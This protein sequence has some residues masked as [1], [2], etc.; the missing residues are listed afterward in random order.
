MEAFTKLPIYAE[1]NAAVKAFDTALEKAEPEIYKPINE[2]FN[3]KKYEEDVKSFSE[4]NDMY[5]E[6]KNV[7]DTKEANMK[8]VRMTLTDMAL[9]FQNLKKCLENEFEDSL[10]ITECLNYVVERMVDQ[11]DGTLPE[12]CFIEKRNELRAK[13]MPLPETYALTHSFKLSSK[14]VIDVNGLNIDLKPLQEWSGLKG[15][16]VLY[17]SQKDG[18]K[19]VTFNTALLHQKNAA[20]IFADEEENVFGYYTKNGINTVGKYCEDKEHFMF[21]LVKNHINCPKQFFAKEDVK[22][23]IFLREEDEVM[24]WIGNSD[25]GLAIFKPSLCGSYSRKLSLVYNNLDDIYLNNT[26]Y[27]IEF[28]TKRIIVI[29][30][31]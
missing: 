1:H 7:L 25:F 22:C 23:G 24:S 9:A 31:N 3:F 14:H 19:N 21:S 6:I 13:K 26:N 27:P 28:T 12:E 15:H 29:Q 11:V 20:V 30:L 18:E 17:D 4:L 8:E 2:K 5:S 16:R 10:Q